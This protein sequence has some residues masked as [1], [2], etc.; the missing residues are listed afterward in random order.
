MPEM[1]AEIADGLLRSMTANDNFWNGVRALGF[2]EV[3]FS[4]D[5]YRR[6]ISKNEFIPWCR[7]YEKYLAALQR[8]K[9]QMSGGL[10]HE[11]TQ[12]DQ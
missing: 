8:A 11:S 10:E 6:S 1:N 2:T 9:A 5:S 4:G 7:D 12:P 3:I